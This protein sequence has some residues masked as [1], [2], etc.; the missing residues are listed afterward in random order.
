[1][2][3]RHEQEVPPAPGPASGGGTRLPGAALPDR[4]AGS[5]R[6]D[7]GDPPEAQQAR[8][9]LVG[10]IETFERPW[11]D[12]VWDPRVLAAMRQVPRH[13]FAPG[14]SMAAAYRD[15]PQ[16]I[17]HD[18]TISQPT[19]VA[20]MSTALRLAGQER[21]LEIGTGSGYQA[22]VLSLLCGSVYSIEIVEPL[23]SAAQE[24]LAR[25]GYRNV[26]VRIGDGY[27]GWPEAAPFDRIML[28][29]AP[30]D[31]P[32]ALVDQLRPGGILVAPVGDDL[33]VLVRWTKTG[34]GMEKERLGG[35]RFVPMVRGKATPDA[36]DANAR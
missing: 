4:G 3:Q 8:A 25:L 6:L 32:Q 29:A 7:R 1:M 18:Q 34:A 35:V 13:L 26:H 33:Q 10:Q 20:L 24:R 30:A 36:R 31:V 15:T 21:V 23:G 22:A 28:T 9:E 27:R 14:L 5:E 16:P 2:R 17:G 12:A 19:I 11:G